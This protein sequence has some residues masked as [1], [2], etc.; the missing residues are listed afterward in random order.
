MLTAGEN[1]YSP[2]EFKPLTFKQWMFPYVKT[3]LK[4]PRNSFYIFRQQGK[5]LRSSRHAA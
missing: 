1:Q 4:N 2:V 3:R 5:L